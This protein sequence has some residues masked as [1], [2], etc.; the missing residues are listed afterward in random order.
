VLEVAEVCPRCS[1]G[2]LGMSD[3]SPRWLRCAR[4]RPVVTEVYLKWLRYTL[5]KSEMAV[6]CLRWLLRGSGLSSSVEV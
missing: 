5:N 6:M 1:L 2:G 4:G 3:V